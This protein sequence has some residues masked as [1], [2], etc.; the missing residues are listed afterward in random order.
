MSVLF[1]VKLHKGKCINPSL[2]QGQ[3]LYIQASKAAVSDVISVLA[4]FCAGSGWMK[5]AQNS[6]RPYSRLTHAANWQKP[7]ITSVWDF[8]CCDDTGVIK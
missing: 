5:G 3:L 6:G 7:V 2:Y 8:S 4:L 1:S